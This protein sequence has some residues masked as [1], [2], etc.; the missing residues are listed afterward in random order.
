M[1]CP[2]CQTAN[3]D[4][5]QSCMNCGKEL[6]QKCSN[7]Q[8]DVAQGALFCAYCGQPVRMKTTDDDQR[9]SRLTSM[10]PGA[11]VQKMRSV[12]ESGKP[13][14]VL[15]ERRT[16]TTLLVDVVSSTTLSEKLDSETSIKLIDRTFE[17]VAHVVYSYEGTIARIL[18]DTVLV[19][20]GAPV[21]HEDDPLRAVNAGLDILTQIKQYG[22]ELRDVLGVEF[23]IRVSI[24]T[25]P[26][27]VGAVGADL[28]YDFTA[29]GGTVNSTA[30]IINAGS[31]MSILITGNTYRFISAYFECKD[32]G[33]LEV[34]GMAKP[35]RVYELVAARSVLG[36]T[37]GFA[38][39]GSPMVGR[40]KE[41]ATLVRTCDAVQAGLG[42]AV[43]IIG[44]PGL[45]KTRLIQE[46]QKAAEARYKIY[47][48]KNP[49]KQSASGRW[50]IGRCVSYRQ[51]MAYQLVIDLLR[52]MIGV[53]IGSDEPETRASLKAYLNNL[54]ADQAN[55]LYPILGH[56]M[57][58]QL[59]ADALQK[60]QITDPQ[61]M[62]TLYL[63]TMQQVLLSLMKKNPVILIL[64]D[65]HWADASSI[66]LFTKLLALISSGPI[67][68]CLVTRL[69]RESA[70]WKLVN[71]TREQLGSSLTEIS[72]QSLTEKE[73]RSLVANLL[74]IE[75]LPEHVRTLI[76]GKAEGNPL[77]MEEVIRM[78]IDRQAIIYKDG[79]WVAQEEVSERDIPDNLQGLLL[80]RIDR[81][82]V[83][84]RYTLLVASVIGRNFPVKVLSQVL[85]GE[86][87]EFI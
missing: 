53:T 44:E 33:L 18:G 5:A 1:I 64:E 61:V 85:E 41:L 9:L 2:H 43:V 14:G 47:A 34:K 15:R 29:Y 20:F 68:I 35:I 84:A 28:T 55:E 78:L 87:H 13:T 86:S 36:R 59:E 69:E 42:R 70:G 24:N 71:A 7:C 40:E 19:F 37:R 16:V 77:F 81:L 65:L 54:L 52:N 66:E 31:P 25:G 12:E 38:E 48:K 83:E 72:L 80:A 50:L 73:S 79:S 4:S 75:T 56:L 11:L 57:G 49:A 23:R 8:S 30:R 3:P 58:L 17:I 67:L 63:T 39:L 6:V 10:A 82:P 76:L 45:G 32:L 51:G 46:W 21:A 60:T 62:Q 74:E 22:Q 26:V 27:I